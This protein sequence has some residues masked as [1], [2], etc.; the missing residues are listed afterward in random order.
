MWFFA[1]AP[2]P[3][4][5]TAEPGCGSGPPTLELAQTDTPFGLADGDALFCGTPPQGGA[6]YAPFRLRVRGISDLDAPWVEI[7]VRD[8]DDVVLGE[9]A[10]AHGFLCANAG[11]DA[12][13]WVASEVHAR[14][15]GLEL[16]DLDGRALQV[17]VT[18]DAA[19][20]RLEAGYE[21]VVAL[22]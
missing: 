13:W 18:V 17:D 22:F 11:N 12:G 6:P 9:A 1:C 16:G 5:D 15:A 20:T 8:P 10:Q 19:G 14:F 4:V 21:G 3:P 7:A 2:P